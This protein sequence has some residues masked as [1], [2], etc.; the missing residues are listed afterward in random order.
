MCTSPLG[1]ATQH[2]CVVRS[3]D[4]KSLINSGCPGPS[5]YTAQPG[6]HYL[7]A[8]SSSIHCPISRRALLHQVDT[9]DPIYLLNAQGYLRPT[10]QVF[11]I[12]LLEYLLFKAFQARHGEALS[13]RS[14]TMSCQVEGRT[15]LLNTHECVWKG[16]WVWILT[17]SL[18]PLGEITPIYE[19]Q[20]PICKVLLLCVCTVIRSGDTVL[21]QMIQ[22]F[23]LKVRIIRDLREAVRGWHVYPARQNSTFWINPWSDSNG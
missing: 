20:C 11:L 6:S 5:H 12:F 2:I 9:E 13:L 3:V 21:T 16:L 4:C 17:Q 23:C 10:C 7:P 19:L 22:C 15:L 8:K 18:C 1:Q 14:G